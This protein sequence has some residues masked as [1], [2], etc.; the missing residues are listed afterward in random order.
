[1]PRQLRAR[2]VAAIATV[3]VVATS[4]M[5]LVVLPSRAE[6]LSGG[7]MFGAWAE[8][9][10]GETSRSAVEALERDL[11]SKLPIV[12]S[13]NRFDEPL[14][15]SFHRWLAAGDRIVLASIATRQADGSELTWRQIADA[16]PGSGI[17]DQMVAL[18]DSAKRLDGELWVIFNH[19]P[20][21]ARNTSRGNS[22][23]FKDAWRALR[24]V[25]DDRGATDVQWVWTMTS[26][27][28]EV[29]RF[30]PNDRRRADLWYPG[31]DWVDY[32]GADPYN[33]NQC[34]GNPAERWES[35]EDT[36]RPFLE[37]SRRHPDKPLLLPE[38]GSTEGAP[39]AKARWLGDVRSLMKE[40]EWRDRFAAIIYFHDDQG[41]PGDPTE[42]SWWLDTSESSLQA[43]REMAQDPFFSHTLQTPGSRTP[44]VPKPPAPTPSVPTPETPKPP[45]STPVP[46]PI[47]TNCAGERA[48]IVGTAGSDI[49]VGTPGR[50]VIQGLGGDDQIVGLGGNDLICG[51]PGNDRLVG[52]AGNDRLLGG[53]GRDVLQGGAG[54]DLLIGGRN[55][56][57]LSGGAGPDR[58]R[59]GAGPD[60]L[61]GNRGNDVL[62]GGH[63]P[64]YVFGNQGRDTLSGGPKSDRC[65][66]G[67]GADRIL[68]DCERRS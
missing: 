61:R 12:R 17:H 42:C 29:E 31:D 64:D 27:S 57:R 56:D 45:T 52:G 40:T 53:D 30:N 60:I 15:D 55:R 16:E 20:E 33:W 41:S 11:G 49:L 21:S 36:T 26:W 10:P 19:E 68:T 37:W 32:L 43:A 24:T 35:L 7:V 48:T 46:D 54:S 63:G 22:Q 8:A 62:R 50:D 1:M 25:F 66:G 34:R 18:A 65:V 44:S 5:V 58:L 4:L 67:T 3:L 2:H 59:G 23:D 39:G 47:S 6:G 51:G 14:D 13:F 9:R 28:F 38:F